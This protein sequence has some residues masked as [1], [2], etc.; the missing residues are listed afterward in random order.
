M[1]YGLKYFRL[2]VVW[3]M[4]TGAQNRILAEETEH[5]NLKNPR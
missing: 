3:L 5:G 1:V 4:M 2:R